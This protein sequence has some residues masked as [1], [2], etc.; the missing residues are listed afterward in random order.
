MNGWFEEMTVT[1]ATA[2]RIAARAKALLDTTSPNLQYTTETLHGFVSFWRNASDIR[3]WAQ[4]DGDSGELLR[5]FFSE[6]ANGVTVC[7]GREGYS[8]LGRAVPLLPRGRALG[9]LWGAR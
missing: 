2:E 1:A 3:A 6:V 8:W 7:V 9:L 4:F 5:V